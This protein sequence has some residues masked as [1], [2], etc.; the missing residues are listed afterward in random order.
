[1]QEKNDGPGSQGVLNAWVTANWSRAVVYARSLLHDHPAAED[2]VQDCFCN[3]LR[4]ADVY[5]LPRDGVPLLMKSVTN[6][7][8][9][10]ITRSRPTISLNADT[11]AEDGAQDG[12]DP[13]DASGAE[14]PRIVLYAELE[15][16]IEA[17]LAQLPEVQRA[18]I[19]LKGLGHSLREIA[20]ILEVSPS[21]AGVM[22]HR[23]R[24]ALAQQLAPFLESKP[25][26][27]TG[28]R[29]AE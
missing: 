5:D 9:K 14:P 6:A 4:K 28:K 29:S 15:R 8:L 23:G 2:V 17:A 18:A 12:I 16:A 26:E 25:D 3:L 27:Q 7:C 20:A 1:L 21:N 24:Q 19:E 22:I 13:I 10:K 11:L